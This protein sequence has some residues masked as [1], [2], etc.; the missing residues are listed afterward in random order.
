LSRKESPAF[1]APVDGFAI[2]LSG[3]FLHPQ[4]YSPGG[5]QLPPL[6][7]DAANLAGVSRQ[8]IYLAEDGKASAKAVQGI[9]DRY[10]AEAI[11]M[12][13]ALTHVAAQ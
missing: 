6:C 5:Q 8:Q 7:E 13:A 1:A 11:T 4:L 3:L 10:R 9:H 12:I 2:A